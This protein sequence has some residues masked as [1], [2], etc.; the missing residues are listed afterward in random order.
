MVWGF[1]WIENKAFK[2]EVGMLYWNPHCQKVSRHMPLSHTHSKAIK[3]HNASTSYLIHI[4][5]GD[6]R[7]SRDVEDE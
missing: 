6:N 2:C 7:Y 5:V 4:T 3:R 1:N